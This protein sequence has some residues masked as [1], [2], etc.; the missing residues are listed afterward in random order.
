MSEQYFTAAEIAEV[1]GVTIRSI[2]NLAAK[3]GWRKQAGKAR[4]R[5]ERGGGW[6]Y[7]IDLLPDMARARLTVTS[8]TTSDKSDRSEL[9]R[10]F[11]G[12]S[13]ARKKACERRLEAVETVQQLILLGMTKTAAVTYV[14]A[15]F[16][17]AERS[18]RSWCSKAESVDSSDRLPALADGYKPTASFAECH[19]MAWSVLKSDY[20]RPEKPS[21]SAC[22]R[23]MKAAAIEHGWSPVP[24]EQSLRRRFKT[25]VGQATI[26]MARSGKDAAKRLYPAQRRDRSD[27]HAMQA[28]DMDGHRFDVF[29]S[30]KEGAKIFRAYLIG[31]QDLYSGKIV[32]WRL[33]QSENK[34]VVRLVIGDMVE[35]HGIPETF[36]ID[37]GRA[38]ASKWITG[39]TKNRYRF[40][41]D[42]NE[43]EGLLT[44]LGI[45]ITWTT[46]YAGQSKPIERSWRDLCEDISKHPFCAGAYT[47]NNPN[48][49]PENYGD[50]AIPF[51]DF[52]NHV[53]RMIAEH[54]ARTGRTSKNASG[55]SFDEVFSE[56]LRQPTTLVRWPTEEQRA[57]WL[58]A[59]DRIT[60]RKGSGEIHIFGNRY[61]A[62]ELNQY[63]GKK[64]T[65]RYDPDN[66]TKPMRVYDLDNRL[67]CIA[68]CIADT[69]FFDTEAARD[70]ASKRNAL[71]KNERENK[72]LH[73]ELSP[74]DLADVYGS[75]ELAEP[76]EPEPPVYKR[77][78]VSN[79]ADYLEPSPDEQGEW[80]DANNAAF[81]RGLKALERQRAAENVLEFPQK[82]KG[83]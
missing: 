39:G 23:R 48:A 49:K 66:L 38:F 20:L 50:R 61:W 74:D 78:A 32:G 22:Y 51:E 14:A 44:T 41:V 11:D 28:V 33:S 36:V 30:L 70:H 31:I 45:K 46:P 62:R 17:A 56:S 13:N 65:V 21:F 18:V 55:R 75:K 82:G 63:A 6:E 9:W 27:L 69:G 72:K 68:D 47:G 2:N 25:E 77:L 1:E 4:K 57:L 76:A 71:I 43:P 35:R 19:P 83:R 24:D 12:L 60:A 73:A 3:Q 58:M 29:C 26:T 53:D 81:S 42:P 52:A 5:N 79:G 34:D 37:N 40:K 54:N 10:Y 7:H 59:S 15:K 8:E 64:V 80:T 67:I 16:C